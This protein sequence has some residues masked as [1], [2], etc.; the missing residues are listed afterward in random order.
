MN[1]LPVS[2]K[3]V[4]YGVLDWGLGHATRSL[5][6]IK[7]LQ[8]QNN[9]VIVASDGLALRWLKNELP[10]TQFLNCPSYKVKY[11]G[12]TLKSIILG[13]AF[14]VG[15]AILKENWKL[16]KWI[17]VYKP[18]ILI[19]DSRFGFYNNNIPSIFITHQINLKAP[20]VINQANHFFLSKFNSI[21]VPDFEDSVLS[22]ELS[23]SNKFKNKIQF[24]GPISRL[25]KKNLS[26]EY[27][28][29]VVLSGPE[30][31]RSRLEKKLLGKLKHLENDII[32]VRGSDNLPPLNSSL[33]H[34]N[35]A[36]TEQ[37]NNVLLKSDKI[38][39]RSGYTSI[40]DYYCLSKPAILIPTPGQTEQEYLGKHLDKK[41][42]FTFLKE[43]DINLF[44]F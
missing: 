1:A 16:K 2:S 33:K 12:K 30:P 24:I 36:G 28:Y 40:L 9:E 7:K 35:L 6:I 8:S 44:T 31:S 34:I 27:R 5:P 14:N 43:K 3:K 10:E 23:R 37:L 39:S 29:C 22:G 15:K 20:L 26:I 42:G 21:W 4:I 17:K 25:Q 13:N 41:F 11:K 32:V 18:N 38:I 19:S